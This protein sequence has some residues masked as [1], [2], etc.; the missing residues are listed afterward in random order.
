M[1]ISVSILIQSIVSDL[2]WTENMKG[3]FLSSFYWGYALGKLPAARLCQYYGSKWIF[4]LCVL[5][6]CLLSFLSPS[7]TRYSFL[8]TLILRVIMGLLQSACYPACFFFY[9]KWIPLQKKTIMIVTLMSSS[10]LVRKKYIKKY[11]SLK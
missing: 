9:E 4:G 2:N 10:Q 3:Y 6:P 11:I 7:V 1:K 8:I 5:I